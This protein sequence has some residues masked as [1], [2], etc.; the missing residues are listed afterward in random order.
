MQPLEQLLS[1]IIT[2][3]NEV[4]NDEG[5]N[6]VMHNIKQQK[7][8]VLEKR[9]P[10]SN[11]DLIRPEILASWIRSAKNGLDPYHYNYPPFMEKHA[12][13]QRLKE[14]AFLRK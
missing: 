2:T 9:I 7:M 12:F 14:K 13:E 8:D 6:T 5:Y 10:P 11:T 4:T 1:P 3:L